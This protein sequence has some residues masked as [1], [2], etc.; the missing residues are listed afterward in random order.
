MAGHLGL[1]SPKADESRR[2]GSTVQMRPQASLAVMFLPATTPGASRFPMLK[3]SQWLGGD[4]EILSE[5]QYLPGRTPSE[6]LRNTFGSPSELLWT[7]TDAR[8]NLVA[9][10]PLPPPH[11]NLPYSNGCCKVPVAW[12]RV[13]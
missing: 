10:P 8:P 6:H 2:P 12:A 7:H 5:L 11:V 3:R 13:K 9:P 4:A 1:W